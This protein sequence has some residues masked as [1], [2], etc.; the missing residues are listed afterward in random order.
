MNDKPKIYVFINGGSPGWYHATALSEDGDF[1]ADH[2][3]SSEGF[4]PH[5]MGL[6]S[7]WKR[8]HYAKQYPDGYELIFVPHNESKNDLG[9]KAAYI[10]HLEKYAGQEEVE[11]FLRIKSNG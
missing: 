3:C 7:D 4:V 10:K 11:N 5:D 8:E 9:I 2:I 1:L 6:T